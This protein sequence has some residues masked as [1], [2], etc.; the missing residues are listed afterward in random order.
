MNGPSSSGAGETQ[1]FHISTEK[2]ED[3]RFLATVS[4]TTISVVGADE[5]K[6]M[7]EIHR[8]LEAYLYNPSGPLSK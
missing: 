3:G 4:G 1:G 6:V 8:R 5:R 7:E 2:A